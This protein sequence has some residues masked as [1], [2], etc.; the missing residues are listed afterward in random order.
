MFVTETKTHL[1]ALASKTSESDFSVWRQW[2]QSKSRISVVSDPTCRL[3]LDPQVS[4]QH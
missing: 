4:E 2:A 3:S 1:G